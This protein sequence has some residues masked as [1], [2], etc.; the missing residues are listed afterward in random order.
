VHE[1]VDPTQLSIG[2]G[3]GSVGLIDFPIGTG[4]KFCNSLVAAES[5]TTAQRRGP[6]ITVGR[7]YN[8]RE[9]QHH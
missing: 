5:G 9:G 6:I 1:R 3:Y 2:G 7:G 4:G 8:I